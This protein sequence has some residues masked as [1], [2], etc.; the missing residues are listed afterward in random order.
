MPFRSLDA[1]AHM[2][3]RIRDISGI[4]NCWSM[5]TDVRNLRRLFTA[6][7]FR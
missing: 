7:E 2:A 3:D 1:L 5:S 6:L 4:S